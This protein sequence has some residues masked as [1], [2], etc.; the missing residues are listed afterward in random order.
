MPTDGFYGGCGCTQAHASCRWPSRSRQALVASG[1]ELCGL[2]SWQKS[3]HFVTSVDWLGA[4]SFA[5]DFVWAGIGPGDHGITGQNAQ[6]HDRRLLPPWGS[7]E[8]AVA[9]QRLAG[10][11]PQPESKSTSARR[12]TGTKPQHV[13]YKRMDDH[14][15]TESRKFVSHVNISFQQGLKKTECKDSTTC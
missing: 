12:T 3:C 6:K 11:R 14:S 10:W 5:L 4:I 15:C 8:Q 9:L 7:G 1:Y 13:G 2:A